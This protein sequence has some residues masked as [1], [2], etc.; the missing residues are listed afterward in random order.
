MDLSA[1]LSEFNLRRVTQSA[2]KTTWRSVGEVKKD[3]R[4]RQTRAAGW[5]AKPLL[6]EI[7]RG[8]RLDLNS[9]CSQELQFHRHGV[10]RGK[11]GCQFGVDCRWS[12]NPTITRAKLMSSQRYQKHLNSQGATSKHSWGHRIKSESNMSSF[13]WEAPNSVR[14][15]LSADFYTQRHH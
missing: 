1:G 8:V 6:Q 15:G 9:H 7:K 5:W 3:K 14:G 13:R 2:P 12:I 4:W 10:L 11:T